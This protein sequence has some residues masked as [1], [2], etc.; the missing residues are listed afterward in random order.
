MSMMDGIASCTGWCWWAWRVGVGILGGLP[1]PR[2]DDGP[3]A[4]D[5]KGLFA[6]LAK[7][8]A[9]SKSACLWPPFLSWKS[10]FGPFLVDFERYPSVILRVYFV[11]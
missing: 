3:S 11:F 10:I 9:S 5:L 2:A 4:D 8:I 1:L 6:G 7:T